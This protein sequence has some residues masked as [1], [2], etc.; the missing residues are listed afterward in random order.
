MAPPSSLGLDDP[1]G[2]T[3]VCVNIQSTRIPGT[4]TSTWLGLIYAAV[5]TWAFVYTL[6]K[7]LQ[8]NKRAAAG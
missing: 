3:R 2:W 1:K 6:R 7:L 4:C 5:L 8:N